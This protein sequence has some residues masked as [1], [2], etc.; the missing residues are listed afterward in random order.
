MNLKVIVAGGG[1]A[2]GAVAMS[3]AAAGHTCDVYEAYPPPLQGAKNSPKAYVI[4]LGKRGQDGLQAATGITPQSVKDGILSPNFVRQTVKQ[5]KLQ[6]RAFAS[7]V[8]PR[9]VLAAHVLEQA[10]QKG[11]KVHYEHRLVDIEFE[12]RQVIL[13]DS[14]GKKVTAKYD[15]LVGADGSKSQ[16]RALMDQRLDDFSVLRTEQD[17]M[18]YQVATLAETPFKQW[19]GDT[20]YSWNNKKYNAIALGFPLASGEYRFAIVFPQ[21]KF[22]EFKAAQKETGDGYDDA[23]VSLFPNLD[24]ATQKD[25]AAQLYQ[26]E[27]ASGGLCVWL[28]ALGS[29]SQG[30]ALVGD[31]GSAMWPSLGQGANCSLESAA[32]FCKTVED[33]VAASST[34]NPTEL[35]SQIVQEFN[36]RRQADVTAADDL[37]YGGIGAKKSRGAQNAPL[38]YKLQIAGMMLLNKLTL[39]LVP[40]PALFRLMLGE[41]LSYSMAHK[42]NFRYEK[43]ICLSAVAAVTVPFVATWFL[44]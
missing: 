14:K 32:V 27:P 11:V 24:V 16:V 5:P 41:D 33:V 3:L 6:T 17:S 36:K 26:G 43:L 15:L 34:T 2:G 42:L 18:E 19:P 31:S 7:L 28:S 30:V 13:Q 35:A 1:P 25:L 12:K 40:K 9:K 37:T 4:S 29:V 22:Q 23:L 44:K 38:S 20:V 21:G 39:G 8:A 10:E